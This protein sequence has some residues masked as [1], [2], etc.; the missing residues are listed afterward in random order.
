MRRHSSSSTAMNWH[1][2]AALEDAIGAS[3]AE[4]LAAVDACRELIGS[5]PTGPSL[6]PGAGP[7]SRGEGGKCARAGSDGSCRRRGSGLSRDGVG[8]TAARAAVLP[9]V[10]VAACGVEWEWDGLGVVDAARALQARLSERSDSGAASDQV[11][12]N[13]YRELEDGL[14][15]GY[16]V[17][18]SED[19]GVKY[20]HVVDDTGR[21]PLPAVAAGVATEAEQARSRLLADEREVIERFLLGEL[22]EEIRERL[23]ESHDLVLAANRGL[24]GVR[25]SHGKGAHL[26]WQIDPKHLPQRAKRPSYW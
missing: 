12:L 13:R 24:A 4:V 2:L 1:A 14:A 6:G 26:N 8:R 19:D 21:Q 15:G 3:V 18:A 5:G 25:T 23:L 10:S 16:D 20:F 22:G 9:G 11:V 7:G 17:V